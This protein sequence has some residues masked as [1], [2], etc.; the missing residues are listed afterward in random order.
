MKG[1]VT[2]FKMSGDSEKK[3]R[4]RYY[5]KIL[6]DLFPAYCLEENILNEQRLNSGT[7]FSL[8]LKSLLLCVWHMCMP[9]QQCKFKE[10]ITPNLIF[11][12]FD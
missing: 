5:L 7:G 1:P 2:F 9:S 12:S 11:I 4:G 8:D 3:R 10:D 6:T